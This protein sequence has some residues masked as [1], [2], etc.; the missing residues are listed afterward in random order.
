RGPAGVPVLGFR[1]AR[2]RRVVPIGD[3]PALEEEIVR[4]V[5]AIGK[6]RDILAAR[7]PGG[8]GEMWVLCDADRRVWLATGGER[9]GRGRRWDPID[10]AVLTEHLRP[11]RAVPE[12]EAI[13]G[14]MVEA[15]FGGFVQAGRE[16]AGVL[17]RLVARMASSGPAATVLELYAGSGFLTSALAPVAGGLVAVESDREAAAALG[18]NAR[19]W[20]ASHVEVVRADAAAYAASPAASRP[21]PDLVVA[22]PPRTG[23]GPAAKAI[24]SL[25]PPRILLVGCDLPSFGRDL[26]ALRGAGYAI[27]GAAAVDMFP[28]THHV[29]AVVLLDPGTGCC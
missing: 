20:S 4:A 27:R 12:I 21:P 15:P 7:Y 14:A 6:R 24:G 28:G 9:L 5:A 13:G 17:G 19:R 25:R 16:A 22:D 11:L 2:G 3:C 18:R 29:E 23:L 26:R 1:A 8:A 10:P